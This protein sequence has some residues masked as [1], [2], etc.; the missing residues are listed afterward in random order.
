VHDGQVTLDGQF[1]HV[2]VLLRG[3]QYVVLEGVNAHS[4]REGV[5]VVSQSQQIT[6]RR[7]I[8]W[9]AHPQK[10]AMVFTVN[11]GSDNVF[12]DVAGWGTGRKIYGLYQDTRTT[13]RR[14]FLRWTGTL[15]SAWK[16]GITHSYYSRDSTTENCIGTWDAAPEFNTA[17]SAAIFGGDHSE[18]SYGTHTFVGNIAYQ[19][20]SQAGR[21]GDMQTI[22]G[23]C[24]GSEQAGMRYQDVLVYRASSNRARG[25]SLGCKASGSHYTDAQ[26]GTITTESGTRSLAQLGG[27]LLQLSAASRPA[28]GAWLRYRYVNGQ[29]TQTPLWPWPMNERIKAAMVA[30]G[31]NKRGGVDGQG[32]IDLTATVLGLGGGTLPEL[33]AAPP[34]ADDRSW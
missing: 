1:A 16:V 10:N 17:Q 2:P 30:S 13:F 11:Y 28:A 25:I 24:K 26:G 14:C 4:S 31:Y 21:I 23:Y 32:G 27:N 6:V 29:L 9:D 3:A 12:E 15:D 18:R 5:V 20:P 22:G 8:A 7:V 19:L 34:K 33:P